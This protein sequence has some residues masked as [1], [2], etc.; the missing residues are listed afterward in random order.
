MTSTNRPTVIQQRARRQFK[1]E[2]TVTA[3]A[4][5]EPV[6]R[7]AECL[8][9]SGPTISRAT[10]SD[11]DDE[12]YYSDADDSFSDESLDEGACNDTDSQTSVSSEDEQD[13]H[14]LTLNE[15][16]FLFFLRGEQRRTAKPR[17]IFM[18][19]REAELKSRCDIQSENLK[20]QNKR[21]ELRHFVS[22]FDQS[23][24]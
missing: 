2:W 23:M 22:G 1:R 6:I 16:L 11:D 12:F 20:N 17:I 14:K 24:R 7:S 3:A 19:Y 8:Q 10:N 21:S 5:C 13:V 15:E 4:P 9:R 18:T